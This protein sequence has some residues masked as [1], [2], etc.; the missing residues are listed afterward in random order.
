LESYNE[1]VVAV[2]REL[3][4]FV[5]DGREAYKKLTMKIRIA[6]TK[7]SIEIWRC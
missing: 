4:E 2:L 6:H 7:L 1:K 3:T 5:N